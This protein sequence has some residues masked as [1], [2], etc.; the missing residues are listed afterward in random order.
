MPQHI[1]R[2]IAQATALAPF[3]R[4]VERLHSQHVRLRMKS[5]TISCLL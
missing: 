5:I 4:T 1:E 3:D 2:A